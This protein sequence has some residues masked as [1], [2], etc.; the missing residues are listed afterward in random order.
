GG[1]EMQ[2][3]DDRLREFYAS[4]LGAQAPP[5]KA[6]LVWADCPTCG[7]KKTQWRNTE[8]GKTGC[9]ESGC[10]WR[11]YQ[12]KESK[13]QAPPIKSVCLADVEM[14]QVD[15]LW[16]NRIPRGLITIVEGIEGV[17]K[18]NLLCAIASEVTRGVGLEDMNLNA[19]S[20]VLW[21]SA[22]D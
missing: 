13:P 4:Q 20:K 11:R 7:G 6:L 18:S 21:L 2:T 12:Q 15:W 22:E 16:E 10:D 3:A 1:A 19:P 9:R 17:G 5:T 14:T 8:T